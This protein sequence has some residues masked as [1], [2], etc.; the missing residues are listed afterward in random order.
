MPPRR[1]GSLL[2]GAALL[3][4]ALLAGAGPAAASSLLATARDAHLRGRHGEAVA[5]LRAYLAVAPQD[6]A[7][8]VWLGASHYQ[9]GQTAQAIDAF[10]RAARLRPSADVLLWLGA[11]YARAG[12]VAEAEDAL[13]QAA[14]GTPPQTAQIARQWLRALRG[15]Q[16]PVLDGRGD[17]AQYRYVVRWYNPSLTAP[18]VEAIVRSVLF[19]ARAYQVDPRLVMALIAVESGFQPQAQSPVGAYGLGQLMPATARALRVDPADP[20]ANIAGSIRYLRAQLDRF[21]GNA[22]LALAAYNAGRGAVSRYGGI[23]PYRETQ[24]YVVNVMALYRH[25]AGS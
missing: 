13:R 18:Q 23:P 17:P 25:L 5:Q 21:G 9:L 14:A 24:W 10:R 11:S 4:A 1:A 19:Y 20:V 6:A 16:A 15:R 2:V 12:R 22:A 7:A 3:L 8:W